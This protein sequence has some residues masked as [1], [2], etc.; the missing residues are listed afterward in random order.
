MG[1]KVLAI[2]S[3]GLL[4]ILKFNFLCI[5]VLSYFLSATLVCSWVRLRLESVSLLLNIC[6]N[7]HA[8][9]VKQT[10]AIKPSVKT[11]R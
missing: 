1:N 8:T 11:L 9:A 7:S 10:K 2:Q 5:A 4:I 6:C 3:I